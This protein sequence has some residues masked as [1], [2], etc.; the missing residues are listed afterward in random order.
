MILDEASIA[1]VGC[2]TDTGPFVLPMAFARVDRYLYLHGAAANHV[3]RSIVDAEVCVT[4]TLIDGLVLSRSAFHHSINYRS[5]V[6]FGR[7]E[8]VDDPAEKRRSLDAL[9]EH[10]VPGRSADTRPPT[11]AELRATL[12]V[13][14]PL[15]EASA[16]IRTGP[17]IEDPDDMA[18]AHWA[19]V[20]P[21]QGVARE[22]VPDG[23]NVAPLPAYLADFV[24][25]R[26]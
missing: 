16:K 23:G 26:S 17:P 1:H 19:G 21:L 24:R 3:L 13:R 4:V 7:G 11:E 18:L 8:L 9:V 22:P 6:I 15:T 5:V 10:L 2:V 20:V 12:V 25:T 14:I